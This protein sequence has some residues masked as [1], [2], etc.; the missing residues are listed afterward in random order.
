MSSLKEVNDNQSLSCCDIF[1]KSCVRSS[2]FYRFTFGIQNRNYSFLHYIPLTRRC[3][4]S[5]VL[6][7]KLH[8]G[9]MTLRVR[10]VLSPL[11]ERNQFWSPQSELS[12]ELHFIYGRPK[13]EKV[14][15]KGTPY[16]VD[17]RQILFWFFSIFTV[18]LRIFCNKHVWNFPNYDRQEMFLH[19]HSRQYR[20]KRNTF[21]L[22][23]SKF[24]NCVY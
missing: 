17:A 11:S 7:V 16:L 1:H 13:R 4:V 19:L 9:H 18:M 21:W 24:L 20:F 2:L 15:K 5:S 8:E 14:V 6:Q 12:R 22:K 23:I 3:F 10:N